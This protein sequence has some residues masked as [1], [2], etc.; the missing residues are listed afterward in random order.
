MFL[1]K[2]LRK[3]K[4]QHCDIR[5]FQSL[6]TIPIDRLINTQD[7]LN[8]TRAKYHSP[9]HSFTEIAGTHRCIQYVTW[10]TTCINA[11]TSNTYIHERK[12]IKKTCYNSVYQLQASTTQKLN[13]RL[14]YQFQPVLR[15]VSY[16]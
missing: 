11:H 8:I 7:K 13:L 4:S 3:K 12:T 5:S 1:K 14:T 10:Y 16:M 2:F 6:F 9:H 15:S